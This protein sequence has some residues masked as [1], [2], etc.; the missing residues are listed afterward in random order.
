[1]ALVA[2][3]IDP[4]EV[5]TLLRGDWHCG[6]DPAAT[7][8]AP[9]CTPLATQTRA[10]GRAGLRR[11]AAAAATPSRWPSSATAPPARATSTRRST[12]PPCS[13]A[14][15][16]FLVQNNGYAISVPLARQSAAPALAYKGVGYGVRSRAG[17]RQRPGRGAGRARPRAVEHARAGDG[18]FLVEAHTYRMERAHQRRRRHPLPRP[19]PRSTRWR[20]RD[21][22][23]RLETYLRGRRLLDDAAVDA[24]ADRGRGRSPR[25]AADPA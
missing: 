12:S 7:R 1:M 8:T 5:L 22:V 4:V 13:R 6:Y 23:A 17:R 14:P 9:Q 15:V 24:V 16:V 19:R 3:G 10:R 21:P 18:P 25:D 11:G 20:G 2:R